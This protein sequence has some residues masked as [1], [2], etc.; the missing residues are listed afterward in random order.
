VLLNL[1]SLSVLYVQDSLDGEPS[2]F[3]DPNALSADGTVAISGTSFSE[4]EQILAYALSSSG[5]DW[6]TIH[7]KDVQT[8][9]YSY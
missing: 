5:S 9:K 2:V 3:L 8:G 7:F 6:V 1:F 4:N